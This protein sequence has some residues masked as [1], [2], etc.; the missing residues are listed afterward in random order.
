[1]D[2]VSTARNGKELLR[3]SIV[4]GT[5]G[6][7]LLDTLVR[8][9]NAVVAWR[10]DIHGVAPE[11]MEGVTFSLRHAQAAMA[12]LCCKETVIIGHALNNDLEALKMSHRRVIDTSFL[13][14]VKGMEGTGSTPSLRDVFKG[15]LGKTMSQEHDSVTDAR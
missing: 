8:P 9:T 14:E 13:F 6:K 12:R 11:H 2:P 7:R 3:L 1:K 10:T 4:E 15:I 5:T